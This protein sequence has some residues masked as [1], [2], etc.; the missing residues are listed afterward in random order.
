MP[1]KLAASPNE[2]R[3]G[4]GDEP[5]T[6]SESETLAIVSIESE[7]SGSGETIAHIRLGGMSSRADDA[8]SPGR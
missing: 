8:N 2:A 3:S 7:D 6:S 1:Q 4:N 5:D